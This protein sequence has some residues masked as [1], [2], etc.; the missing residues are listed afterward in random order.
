MLYSC[1][2]VATVGVKWLLLQRDNYS[3]WNY[4]CCCFKSTGT[5]SICIVWLGSI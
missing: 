1:T 5:N 2:D 4:C 3:E